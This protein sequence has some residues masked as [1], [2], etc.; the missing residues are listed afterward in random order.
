MRRSKVFV[1]TSHPEL[2]RLICDRLGVPEG[3]CTLAKFA[4]GETSVAIGESIRDEDCYIVQ[5]GSTRINDHLMELLI[6]ISACRGGSANKITA[7]VPYFPYSKQSK[8]KKHRG[9]ITARMI[10]NLLTMAGADHVITMDLHAS[11]MQGFFTKPVDNLHAGPTLA[12]WI[13]LNIPEWQDAVV[14]SK[15]PGG[16]KRVTALADALKINFAMINTDRRRRNAFPISRASPTIRADDGD[17]DDIDE[18]L[19]NHMTMSEIRSARVVQ[20]HVVDDDYINPIE[21]TDCNSSHGSQEN[22]FMYSSIYSVASQH[23]HALGG[24]IDATGSDDEEEEPH[25]ERLITLVGDVKDRTAIIVDDMI[26]RPTSFIAA[27]EH[28]RMNCGA[29]QVYVIATHGVFGDDCLEEMEASKCIDRI[30]VTN[31]FPIT[32]ETRA[33]SEKL[34]VIDISAILAEC[35]RRNHY[36]ESISALFD[37]LPIL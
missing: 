22:D 25:S 27:A 24:T 13:K 20:G 4:N 1:G 15:N 3:K 30:V 32:P 6:M 12:R 35:M 11:Q 29:K 18:E 5:S 36:G 23:E 21:E 8:M 28:C 19:P 16:T 37:L 33:R 34:T 10:A 26:D 17:D 14:V 7:V 2:G 9:A 31:T